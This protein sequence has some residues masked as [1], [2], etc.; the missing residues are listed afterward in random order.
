M[1][2]KGDAQIRRRE[3]PL[4]V[5][6]LLHGSECGGKRDKTRGAGYPRVMGERDGAAVPSVKW[7][8]DTVFPRSM[9]EYVATVNIDHPG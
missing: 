5:E 6:S 2:H 7:A 3:S 9:P 1:S 8:T 4:S